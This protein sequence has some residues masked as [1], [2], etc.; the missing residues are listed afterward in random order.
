MIQFKISTDPDQRFSLILNNKRVTFRF[1]YNT[2]T[3]RWSFDIALDDVPVL[4][5]RRVVTGVDLIAPFALGIGKLFAVE[6]VPGAVPD[7]LGLPNG[8]VRFYQVSDE[9]YDAA[10]S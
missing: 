9:E 3:D 1:R 8:I 7:R 2:E 6:N 10:V 4:T 5:G